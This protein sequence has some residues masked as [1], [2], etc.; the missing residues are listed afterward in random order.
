M[1][2]IIEAGFDG[3][4]L[5]RADVWETMQPVATSALSEAQEAIGAAKSNAPACEV[6]GSRL[7]VFPGAQQITRRHAITLVLREAEDAVEPE[8]EGK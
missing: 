4:Y 3:V 1:R 6:L 5:D 7:S 8:A 2:Q